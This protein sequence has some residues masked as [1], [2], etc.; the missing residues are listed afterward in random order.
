MALSSVHDVTNANH[1]TNGNAHTN[2]G[3]EVEISETD[4][5]KYIESYFDNDTH[6]SMGGI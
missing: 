4:K 1:A 5:V 3:G 6:P 2:G